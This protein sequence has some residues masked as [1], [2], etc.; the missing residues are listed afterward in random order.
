MQEICAICGLRPGTTRDHVPPKG[1]FA[2]PRPDN[3]ITVP[4]CTI[5][6][7][8]ASGLDERFLVNLGIHVSFHGGEGGRL[9]KE[10]VLSTLGHNKKLAREVIEG[11]RKVKLEA[12]DGTFSGFA[13]ERKWDDTAHDSVIERTI[14]GLHYHHYGEV[15]GS[16]S[17]V[18]VYFFK[19]LGDLVE[20]STS[21]SQEE[22]GKG[23][24]LYRHTRAKKGNEV[25]SLWLFQFYSMHWAGG[26]AYAQKQA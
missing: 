8:D 21:W 13:Y 14:R 24:V 4:A 15:L 2:K 11:M 20:I 1:I 5:C 26:S 16:N 23:Q 3:L 22:L 25:K 9:F 7:N 17:K 19:E 6:N 12:D 10:R 18:E